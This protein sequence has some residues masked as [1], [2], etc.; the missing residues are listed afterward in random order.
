LSLPVL[1]KAFPAGLDAHDSEHLK[2][3]RS[4]YEEWQDNQLG[5]K[6]E[7]AIH[8]AWVEFVLKQTLELPDEVLRSGQQIPSGMSVTVSEQ[9]ETLRPDWVI[10]NPA[11]TTDS[12]KPQLL[13]QIVAAEQGL[14]KPL[15]GSRWAASPATRMMELLHTCNVRLGM[16]TN[17]EHWM[18]VNAPK[19]ETTGFI[20]W[21]ST[22]W[23]E[24]HLTLRAFRS[25]LGVRRFFGVDDSETLEA[26]LTQ[27][28]T[29]QQ[30]VT[31]QLGYQVRRAVEVLV[32]AI[33]LWER[34]ANAR[35]DNVD[36]LKDVPESQLYEAALTVM[37]RLV[38]LFCAEE[39]GLLLLGD[40]IY[41][42]HYAVSTL[43]EQ[44]RSHAD[45]HGEEVLERR[46]DAWCRL[47][48]TFRAVYGGVFH[49]TL[50]LPAYGGSLFDPLSVSRGARQGD[51][52]ADEWG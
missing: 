45:Q 20:S 32:Q 8:R 9:N 42:Q 44:L 25:L 24:E 21:Y 29:D 2:L 51:G 17:G 3:L 4:A 46:S 13:V 36:L 16:V 15:K 30:E 38:F 12:G 40:P 1:L 41:D 7:S 19:G 26:L 43:R 10:V 49:D 33:S 39:R 48:A 28:L 18:L 50:Q 52:V 47:L 5:L 14:E 22:L 37:M 31:D 11:E 35:I 27:S 6:P 34:S 23:V